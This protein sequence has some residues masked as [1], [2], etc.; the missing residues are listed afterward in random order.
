ML[1]LRHTRATDKRTASK[2]AAPAG[3]KVL[4]SEFR[5]PSPYGRT[6]QHDTLTEVHQKCRQEG[7]IHGRRTREQL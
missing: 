6:R 2:Y 3:L 5:S 7:P 4:Q 1:I